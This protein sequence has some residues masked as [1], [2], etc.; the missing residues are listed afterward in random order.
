MPD[1][2]ASHP[3]RATLSVLSICFAYLQT[4]LL[5]IGTWELIKERKFDRT[6][7][8]S[9]IGVA[10]TLATITALLYANDVE[11]DTERHF[12]RVSIRAAVTGIGFMIVGIWLLI[13]PSEVKSL[14]RK[15][16]SVAFIIYGLQ[17]M[18]YFVTGLLPLLDISYQI[19]YRSHLAL[20]D[21]F[22]LA[23][24]GVGM[25][26]WL[27]ENERR[28]LEKANADLDSFFYSTSHDLR[29][30]IASILGLTYLAKMESKDA[31]TIELFEKI[32]GRVKKLDEVINDILNYSKNTKRSLSHK[33]LDFTALLDEVIEGVEFAKGA[34]QIRLIYDRDKDTSFI[35]DKDRLTAILNNLISNAVRYHD[36]SKSDPYIKVDFEKTGSR[37]IITV[38]D[39]G[40]GIEEK[41]H[42][43]IFEMFYRAS[44]DSQGS[45][46]GL[47]IVRETVKKL[48]GSIL[49]QS[50]KG[51][52]S[53][54]QLNLPNPEL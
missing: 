50:K 7:L 17:Q 48:K 19:P 29:S 22:L 31:E 11:A 26:F 15:L 54:F 33:T 10:L 3:L 21:F 28:D 25:L 52:G 18:H 14:G 45:G 34:S 2:P 42:E 43:K 8:W 16:L 39:N 36:L 12:V 30:P 6:K 41:D 46:L 44:N 13:V 47:F 1:F 37:I 23:L 20:I 38:E 51:E 9:L 53:V 49:L 4:V 27:L 40:V 32:E 35:G 5:T 24:M